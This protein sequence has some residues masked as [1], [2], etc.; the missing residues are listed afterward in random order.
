MKYKA[1]ILFEDKSVIVCYKP[2]GIAVQTQKNSAQDMVSIL[3]NYRNQKNE[4]P[5]IFLIH[6]LDQPVEGIM[7][8]GKTKKAASVLSA[9][10]SRNSIDK[11]YLA[12]TDHIVTE[13]KGQL[14]DYLLRDGK[15]NTSK[16][17]PK[18]T[19]H[20]KLATLSYHCVAEDF[21]KSLVAIHLETG[22]H[23]QIRV[24][25]ANAG[26]P[27]YGDKKYNENA[28]E[29][30]HPVALC[31]VYLK[32]THPTSKKDMEFSYFP[33]NKIFH[34]FRINQNVNDILFT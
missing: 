26:Y 22:R 13:P 6:R 31:S 18:G 11:Y 7:V 24:Q 19:E 27:L 10:L 28:K 12:V 21:G 33:K 29:E 3:R 25:M 15:T 5:D 9:Q 1:D 30:Y 20:A 14:K 8:F 34:N 23:H 2:S 4:D 32:F 16:V 17:V